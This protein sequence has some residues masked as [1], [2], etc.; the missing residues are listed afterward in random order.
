M[1]GSV[2]FWLW[3]KFGQPLLLRFSVDVLEVARGCV[4][5]CSVA[6]VHVYTVLFVSVAVCVLE[7]AFVD[8]DVFLWCYC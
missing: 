6:V 8:V 5:F 7:F 3:S 1:R 2:I 4:F